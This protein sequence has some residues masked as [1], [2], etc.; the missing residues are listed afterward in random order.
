MKICKICHKISATD[1]DHTDCIQRRSIETEDRDFKNSITEK[2]N[3]SKND[4]DL[5]VEV[6]A[7]L[8]HLGRERN[9]EE[10]S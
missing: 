8:E 10:N 2:L 1:N 4:Q 6:K 5:G 7:I 9:K 3:L